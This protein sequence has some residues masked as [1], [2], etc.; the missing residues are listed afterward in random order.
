METKDSIHENSIIVQPCVEDL[1]GFPSISID[2]HTTPPIPY[3]EPFH[4]QLL[5][6]K[7][8]MNH[9]EIAFSSF[10]FM[11][12]LTYQTRILPSG[13][14]IETILMT[15]QQQDLTFIIHNDSIVLIEYLDIVLV[16]NLYIT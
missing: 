3:L 8:Y 7:V 12:P 9:D 1:L 4:L 14:N 11:N 5:Q 10:G 6:Y 13:I 15:L 2:I 16:M